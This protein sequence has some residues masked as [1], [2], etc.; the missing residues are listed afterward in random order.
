MN[1]IRWGILGTMW[2]SETIAK[3]IQTS[4]N[5][6]LTAI[7]SRSLDTAKA[8]ACKYKLKKYYDDYQRLLSDPEIDAIYIGLPNHLHK[9]WIIKSAEAGKHILCEKPF[10][11]TIDEAEEVFVAVKKYNVFCM[12]ALMYRFHPFTQFFIDL[13]HSK[14]IGEIKSI[15]ATYTINIANVENKTAG[16]AVRNLGCYPLSL[17]RLIAQEEPVD[18]IF[19]GVLNSATKS[20]NASM[21]QLK[22]ANGIIATI[23]T[24]NNLPSWWQFTIIGNKGI[25][26]IKSNPWL[27]GNNNQL[28]V[29]IENT[30]EIIHFSVEKP[31]YTYQIEFAAEHIRKKVLS[32]EPH[33]ITWEH[34]LGNAAIIEKWLNQI[35]YRC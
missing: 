12:E 19:S 3:A 35:R 23:L 27:P 32:P 31:L 25:I 11:L 4:N 29:K 24:A 2:I 17:T 21:T 8:F 15:S 34:S 28:M 20:D 16:G 9:E 5:S 18:M 6:E 14:H 13:A 30:E 22:F 26:D 10:V 7:G 1:K 33:G